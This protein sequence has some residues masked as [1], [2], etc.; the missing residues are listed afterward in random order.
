[1]QLQRSISAVV[2]LGY[3]LLVVFGS[4]PKDFRHALII[5]FIS[6]SPLLLPLACIWFPEEMGDYTGNLSFPQITKAT[7]AG[8]IRVGGWCL[9]IFE[10]LLLLALLGFFGF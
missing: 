6:Y 5:M 3:M 7:P 9:L 1:M 10:F 2:A 8:V 4:H